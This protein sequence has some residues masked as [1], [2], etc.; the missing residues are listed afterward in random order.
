MPRRRQAHGRDAHNVD[1]RVRPLPLGPVLWPG[2]GVDEVTLPSASGTVW[3]RRHLGGEPA[4]VSAALATVPL[5][6]D[7]QIRP[8][9]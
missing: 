4:Q 2:E 5:P 1:V 6:E 8:W 7:A 9:S 3:C